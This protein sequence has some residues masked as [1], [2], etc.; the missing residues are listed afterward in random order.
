MATYNDQFVGAST[1]GQPTPLQ[2]PLIGTS[3]ADITAKTVTVASSKKAEDRLN[4]I[5]ADITNIDQ[6]IANQNAQKAMGMSTMTP[7]EEE[8]RKVLMGLSDSLN[9]ATDAVN[10]GTTGTTGTGDTSG[11]TGTGNAET[12]ALQS[13]ITQGRANLD[14][15]F[16]TFQQ[17]AQSYANGTLPLTAEQQ[18]Q[19]NELQRQFDNAKQ[20]QLKAN[21]NFEGGTNIASIVSGRNRYAPEI[22]LG[23]LKAAVD[24]GNAKIADIDAKAVAAVAQ[25]KQ[26]YRESNYKM[27]ESAYKIY[28]DYQT[29]KSQEIQKQIDT[30]TAAAKDA[31]DYAYETIE[32]PKNDILTELAKNGAPSEIRVSVMNAPTVEEALNNAG[33]WLQTATGQMGDYLQYKR[34]TISQGL[35]PDLYTN[36]KVK[37]DAAQSKAK[38]NEAY[39]SAYA[40]AKGKAAADGEINPIDDPSLVDPASKSI[41]AQTGLSQPA[42]EYATK[43]VSALARLSEASRKKYMNEWRD[44]QVKNNIDSSTFKSQYEALNAVVER[45]TKIAAMTGLSANDM[46]LSL[47]NLDTIVKE[48]DLGKLKV[49]NV[50]KEWAGTETNDELAAKYAFNLSDLRSAL[51]GF[52]AAQ[53]GKTSADIP[54]LNEASL[55][56]KNGLSSGTIDGLKT[57]IEST[58]NRYTKIASQSVNTAQKQV[59]DM[60]GVGQNYQAPVDNTVFKQKVDDYT[61]ANLGLKFKNGMDVQT[62]IANGYK[63]PGWTDSD[64]WDLIQKLQ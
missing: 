47:D 62:T 4:N 27:I 39:A 15:A 35:T 21:A 42:F 38:A 40:S 11:T 13:Q 12:D 57:T 44:Y 23:Q 32:K 30:V 51:A 16:N 59:W 1:S 14:A 55:V 34:D 10:G 20:E 3:L 46:L 26:G 24:S 41:L 31:R 56:I 49:T 33:D 60:F 7:S 19:V 25:M 37:D 48:Q 54:D 29:Q 17:Q 22:A 61:R 8:N 5:K 9:K 63:T 36:W 50:M 18:A 58:A 45:N 2:G 52:F 43:G 53:Q 28:Q 6:G 64:V